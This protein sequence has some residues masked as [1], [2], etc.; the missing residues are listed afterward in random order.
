MINN[1]CLEN[2]MEVF[3]ALKDLNKLIYFIEI[4]EK[5]ALNYCEVNQKMRIQ[6]VYKGSHRLNREEVVIYN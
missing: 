5:N 4:I 1:V 2:K 3:K 6:N